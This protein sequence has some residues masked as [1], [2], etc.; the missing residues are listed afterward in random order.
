MTRKSTYFA[1]AAVLLMGT[2]AFA[3]MADDHGMNEYGPADSSV[4]SLPEQG[5]DQSAEGE[6]REPVGTGAVPSTP[7][8][9]LRES[10]GVLPTVEVGGRTYRPGIDLG[11]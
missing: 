7:E 2:M 3:A 6:I 11:E 8:N 5:M 10:T 9:S 4:S 1:L